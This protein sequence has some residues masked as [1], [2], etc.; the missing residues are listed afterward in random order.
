M[1]GSPHSVWTVSE[2]T[3]VDCCTAFQLTPE[4]EPPASLENCQMKCLR[5]D[6]CVGF[7]IEK[8]GTTFRRCFGKT[9][10]TTHESVV[11]RELVL[12]DT[13]WDHYDV[14]APPPA[15]PPPEAGTGSRY[16]ISLASATSSSLSVE[17]RFISRPGESSEAK[18]F[19]LSIDNGLHI[20]LETTVYTLDGV[21]PKL[22]A[23][24]RPGSKHTFKV[25]AV[26]PT[27]GLLIGPWSEE[28]A[29]K[30]LE[31][32]TCGGDL[33]WR[34]CA[35]MCERTCDDPY[36]VCPMMCEARC[37]C[38]P[39]APIA[40]V[41]AFGAPTGEC[42]PLAHCKKKCTEENVSPNCP[43]PRCAE[44]PRGCT[45]KYEVVEMD[46]GRC[47]PKPCNYECPLAADGDVNGDGEV[48]WCDVDF[49][50]EL[51]DPTVEIEPPSSEP[52]CASTTDLKP[53]ATGRRGTTA[54]RATAGLRRVVR[55]GQRGVVPGVP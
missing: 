34:E 54:G 26:S 21:P 32:P 18:L 44:P 17:W 24:L 3:R 9:H 14:T 49:M 23:P 5:T 2:D 22:T 8:E 15:P 55:D 31:R 42:R 47:C 12:P 29:F 43:M 35:S 6:D 41:D 30:T 11:G 45:L 46:D 16:A 33:V 53:C 39:R 25:A 50:K 38:P 48:N 40:V 28:L 51:I 20:K 52:V 19:M 4:T 27:T 36:P 7:D 37:A 13:N 1:D 10:R